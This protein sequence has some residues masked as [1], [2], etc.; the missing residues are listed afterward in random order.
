MVFSLLWLAISLLFTTST[1][2]GAGKGGI[3]SIP[4]MGAYGLSLN[5]LAHVVLSRGGHHGGG[6][7]QW[8]RQAVYFSFPGQLRTRFGSERL[9]NSSV[10][11]KEGT[12]S[13]LRT[14][15]AWKPL[16]NG[17]AESAG[18][19]LKMLFLVSSGGKVQAARGSDGGSR[20][21]WAPEVAPA[22]GLSIQRTC[23]LLFI[24][25]DARVPAGEAE[26]RA[27]GSGRGL[28]RESGD[29]KVLSAPLAAPPGAP[30]LSEEQDR[31]LEIADSLINK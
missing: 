18:G 22:L 13:W 24:P 27:R 29:E 6:T 11:W 15:L 31:S 16:W 5:G 23:L 21:L 8:R 26:D 30:Q 10:L 4:K 28:G 2:R 14:V 3:L 1:N 12:D 9:H 7:K 25:R 19:V 17:R 20:T